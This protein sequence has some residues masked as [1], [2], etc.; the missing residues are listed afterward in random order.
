MSEGVS[1][2]PIALLIAALL[3]GAAL[4]KWWPSDERAVR[5]QLD[6]LADTITVPSTDIDTARLTRLAELRNYFAPE[7]TVR[8]DVGEAL[9]RELLLALAERWTPPPGGIFVEFVYGTIAI[10]DGTAAVDLTARI[11][12]RDPGS[13]EVTVDQRDARFTL[14]KRERAWL[15]T[16]VESVTLPGSPRPET[17]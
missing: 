4:F 1:G 17:R 13:G 12:S 2:K 10:G 7:A 6:N 9:S 11:S 3:I 5:R 8:L 16:G 14:A 15:I